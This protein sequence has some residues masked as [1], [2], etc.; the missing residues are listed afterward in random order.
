MDP[1]VP[2]ESCE[3]PLCPP[4]GRDWSG[5]ADQLSMEVATGL[6]CDCMEQLYGSSLTTEKT[7]VPLVLGQKD[8]Q[9]RKGKMVNGKCNCPNDR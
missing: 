7:A 8:V 2:I 5:E 3:I 1:A 4:E 6:D 9:V